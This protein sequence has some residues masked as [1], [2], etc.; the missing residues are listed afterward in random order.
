MKFHHLLV[1]LLCSITSVIYAQNAAPNWDTVKAPFSRRD[2]SNFVNPDKINYPETWFHFIDGNVEKEGITKDLEAIAGA[3]F[4][5]VQFFHG[6][7]AGN[8]KDVT[9]CVPCLSDRWEDILSHTA[10]EAERLGL[11]FTM[12]NCPGWSMAGGPWI[13][14]ENSMRELTCKRTD[15]KGG[16]KVECLLPLDSVYYGGERDYRDLFVLAFPRPTGD[17]TSC[18]IPE[19]VVCDTLSEQLLHIASGMLFDTL[20]FA[21]GKPI[22]F[23]VIFPSDT[24]IRT[25]VMNKIHD[26]NE[27][28]CYEPGARI[29]IDAIQGDGSRIKVLDTELPAGAWQGSASTMTL[30]MDEVRTSVLHVSISH[31]YD[32]NLSILHFTSAARKNSWESE[33]GWELGKIPY[34]AEFPVQSHSSYVRMD[35]IS[36]I[37]ACMDAT[38]KLVW[39][40]PEGDWV[41][42]RIGHCSNLRKNGPAPAEA[43]GFE[44][45]KFSLEGVNTH[46]D[47]YIGKYGN[48]AIK[49][50]LNGMLLDSWECHNQ[51]W[52]RDM[53]GKFKE[54]TGYNLRSW[55][56]A[57]FG[58]VI[59]DQ[60]ITFRFLR[61]WR[62]VINHLMVNNFYGGMYEK[63]KSMG[64]TIQY[65]TSGGDVCPIDIMEYYKY[66]DIPMTEFWHNEMSSSINF[67]PI[68]PAAS[69]GHIYGKTRVS[70][71]AFTSGLLT[72]NE[73]LW[74]L[75]E[76]ANRHIAHGVSH[77]VFH[78]YTHNPKADYLKPG[79]CLGAWLGTPFLRGQ[80]WWRFM[81]YFTRYVARCTYMMERGIPSMDVLWFLG[82]DIDHKPDQV[83]EY[84]PGYNYDYCNPDVLMNRLEVKDGCLV[85]PEGLSYRILWYPSPKV[86]S[87]E[88][89]HRL[90]E[91][92]REGAVLVTDRPLEYASMM[93]YDRKVFEKEM[94]ELY[95][96]GKGMRKV[97]KGRVYFGSDIVAAL[98]AEGIA[99]DLVSDGVEWMHRKTDGADWY[100]VGAPEGS[101]YKGRIGFRNGGTAEIWDPLT[102]TMK[103]VSSETVN[104]R[105]VIDVDMPRCGSMFVVFDHNRKSTG[106]EVQSQVSEM[107]ISSDWT[108]L[109]PQGWGLPASL[110]MDSLIAWKDMETTQEGKSFSGTVTYTREVSLDNKNSGSRYLLRLGEVDMVAEVRVNGHEY[111]PLWT[112]PFDVDITDALVPGTNVIEVKVTTTWFNRMIYDAGQEES[113]R[114]TWVLAG[115]FNYFPL[116]KT[117][118]FGPVK[119]SEIK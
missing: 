113:L 51:T 34:E 60:R 16:V 47:G 56:P 107:D 89:L 45:D 93:D 14:P 19:R 86:I 102:G 87:A 39:D 6:G 32:L 66:A 25:L 7:F 83:T 23:D 106:V 112:W 80:T 15:V 52:T 115:P 9:D 119:I 31:M 54:Y 27:S 103:E 76:N 110:K 46:F 43:T 77:L 100:F 68:R 84:M 13:T 29:H 99:E 71:E 3:G 17:C 69:A 21:A 78:T 72:W 41:V 67:K 64:L 57:L 35:A 74:Q 94:K 22:E 30:A 116:V 5:G 10:K 101:G 48:G 11:R 26:L 49:G 70:A 38:G 61:D 104:G 92:V 96:D 42:L 33:A 37:T 20:S 95:G 91:L 18:I 75:K 4:S 1:L 63:A 40:A 88:T 114:K 79:T 118:L 62:Y 73:H 109:F 105:T 53:E 59:D 82:D 2:S 12:Q 81:P 97:G 117:G 50:L 108:V 58:Y 24:T 85:T 8:W 98:H 65:E 44:C 55:V 90:L 36:D 28:M 111:T